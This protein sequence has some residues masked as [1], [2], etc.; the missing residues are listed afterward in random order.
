MNLP[1]ILTMLRLFLTLIFIFFLRQNGLVPKILALFAFTLAAI[2]DFLDGYFARKLN[3]IS[4]FGKIMD[5][6]ADKFL[7][8]SAFFIFSTMH[9]IAGWMFIVICVREVVVTGLRLIAMQKGI[10]L[11][12]EEAGKVKTVLQIV[13]VYL[14]MILII[15]AQLDVNAQWYGNM[16]SALAGGI[17]IFMVGIVLI[18]SW[19]GISFIWNN[20]KEIFNVR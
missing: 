19:S 10:A 18:T 6:I 14:I 5:P 16:M 2:T 12:A 11:A 8:L 13:A 1:N 20:R 15:L 7:I 3:L 9:I 4:Q 17:T